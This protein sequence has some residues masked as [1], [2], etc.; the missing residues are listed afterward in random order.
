MKSIREDY[1]QTLVEEN[2]LLDAT[3]FNDILSSNSPSYKKEETNNTAQY[4]VSVLHSINVRGFKSDDEIHKQL[5]RYFELPCD[6]NG[7]CRLNDSLY[8]E[9][10]RNILKLKKARAGLIFMSKSGW[11]KFKKENFKDFALAF[12]KLFL[13]TA[14]PGLTVI[15]RVFHDL[16]ESNSFEEAIL[17]NEY[18]QFNDCMYKIQ[19]GEK[20]PFSFD[21]VPRIKYNLSMCDSGPVSTP[22]PKFADFVQQITAQDEEYEKF[23]YRFLARLVS[24]IDYGDYNGAILYGSGSNGKSI[25]L[26]LIKNLYQSEDISTKNLS[27]LNN[28]FGRSGLDSKHIIISHESTKV[29]PNSLAL[30][31]LKSILTD[32]HLYIEEKGKDGRDAY[33]DLKVVMASNE[34]IKFDKEN[35]SAMKRRILVLPFKHVVP[36]E[37]KDIKLLDKLLEEKNEIMA[38]LMHI[39]T[40]HESELKT[41]RL[42][43]VVRTECDSWFSN[44]NS[45]V[46][47][48][49]DHEVKVT[50]WIK[51]NLTF[52]GENRILQGDLLEKIKA[53][54]S[55][56][57]SPQT[58]NKVL[59]EK[60]N[61]KD[62]QSNGNRYWKNVSYK[63]KK[64]ISPFEK[65]K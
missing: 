51:N 53:E 50:N 47:N 3:F 30:S 61:A 11:R 10:F 62:Q 20:L 27:D 64:L 2:G 36:E 21:V 46:T 31:T 8:A 24:P 4:A 17:S 12:V 54:V 49:P 38:Y 32:K 59:R 9:I 55:D 28:R 6:N 52:D 26:Y 56:T 34:K 42:P 58:I 41:L 7:L 35:Q 18:M 43:Q 5:I 15:D 40:K 44:T 14:T 39:M 48:K 1:K 65:F 29:T 37:E 57:I 45:L 22:P 16:L 33:V 25:L 23:L 13:K 19:T 63:T 60:F